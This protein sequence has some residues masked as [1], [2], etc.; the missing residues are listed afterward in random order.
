M[1][2]APGSCSQELVAAVVICARSNQS[3]FQ[4][5]WGLLDKS[6][7]LAEGLWIMIAVRRRRVSS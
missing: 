6:S 2:S 1:S 5:P 3:A 4:H 7:H